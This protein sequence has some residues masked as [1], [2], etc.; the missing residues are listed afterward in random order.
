MG[1][2]ARE[3]R[4]DESCREFKNELSNGE[5]FRLRGTLFK[6]ERSRAYSSRT[7]CSRGLQAGVWLEGG[8][9]SVI[10]LVGTS[11]ASDACGMKLPTF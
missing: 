1:R 7:S 3:D 4:A 10:I 6:L 11:V 2:S 5:A 8:D 9:G